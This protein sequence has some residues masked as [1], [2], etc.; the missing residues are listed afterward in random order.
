M[1]PANHLYLQATE[2]QRT[3]EVAQATLVHE[4]RRLAAEERGAAIRPQPRGGVR[5]PAI[6]SRALGWQPA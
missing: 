2:V 6:V 3:R 1:M 5:V 4:A